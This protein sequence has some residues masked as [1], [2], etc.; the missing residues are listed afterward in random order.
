MSRLRNEEGLTLIELTVAAGMGLVLALTLFTFMDNTSKSSQRTAARVDAAKVGRP[1]LAGIMDTLHTTCVAPGVA[2]ILAGSTDTTMSVVSQTGSA[3]TP[4]PVKR[5]ISYSAS[6]GTLS[7]SIYP[8]SSGTAP[9]W[10]FSA[11]PTSTRQILKPVTQATISNAPVPIFRYYAFDSSGAIS[12][13][14]LTVPL[15][16]DDAAKAVQAT[17]AFSVPSRASANPD[18]EGSASFSDSAL[19]RFTPPGE[20]ASAENLPCA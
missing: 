18:P 14:P 19:F 11:T 17:V 1:A 3:V 6:T 5:T 9:T 20:S 12:A 8:V 15:S 10:T 2:P 16:D 13:T 4:V 7:E